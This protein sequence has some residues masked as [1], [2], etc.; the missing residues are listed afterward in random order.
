M[1][2][3]RPEGLRLGRVEQ[4]LAQVTPLPQPLAQELEEPR[5]LV[6]VPRQLQQ[7]A[8]LQPWEVLAVV[9]LK[10]ARPRP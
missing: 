5:Q 7:A 4:E 3:Q 2:L 8:M 10:E 9:L 6:F 1:E